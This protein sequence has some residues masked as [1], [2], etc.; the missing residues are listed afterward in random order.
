M[1]KKKTKKNKEKKIVK[2]RKKMVFPINITP[3]KQDCIIVCNGQISDAFKELDKPKYNTKNRDKTVEYYKE[4][5]KDYPD[6]FENFNGK[7]RLYTS[8]PS[9]YIML[10]SHSDSW[11]DTVSVVSHE[12]LHLTS[13]VLRR[14][15]VELTEESEEAFTY[16]HGDIM[17]KIFDKIF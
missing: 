4:R 16:L 8:L 9:G 5:I 6:D 10:I 3:Y 11:V 13:Y 15:G 12:A 14:A 17:E 7:G 1:S 2:F